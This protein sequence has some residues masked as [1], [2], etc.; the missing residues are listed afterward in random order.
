M[1]QT[2]EEIATALCDANKKVQLIYAF[3]GTGKTRLSR[4]L[5]N[6]IDPKDYESTE[7][8]RDAKLLY[9]N[10]F[11]E[12]LFYWDNDLAGD[13]NRKLIIRPN[14]Y[15]HSVF[16]RNGLEE[17]VVRTFQRYTN[18]SLNAVLS[19][20]ALEV[21][22]SLQRGDD[23]NVE[24]LKISKG[25]ESNFI[26]SIFYCLLDQVIETR[27]IP[28]PEDRDNQFDALEYIVIDDPV[29]SLDEGHLIKLAVDIAELIKKSDYIGGQG[30]RF[31]VTTHNA[32]FFNVLHNELNNDDRALGYR[33]GTYK[34]ARLEKLDEESFRIVDQP[35][36][37]PFSYH[38]H[39]LEELE[40]AIE[41]DDI[42]KYHFNF[43]RNLL[44][45][46]ATF[47][48]HK[49]WE[50]LLPR[51]S[52]DRPNPYMKRIL[53]LSSH[54]KHS[55]EEIPVPSDDDKRMLAYIVKN[56]RRNFETWN[57]EQENA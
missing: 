56:I 35:N 36:D 18:D 46:S 31:I 48:G 10:A 29:S 28:D 47:L 43:V 20:D 26:W 7:E 34:K 6:L 55:G 17:T 19:P 25:E 4:A 45:K 52:D 41:K 38:I 22:F 40:A 37:S 53:N 1:V 21:T 12:D 57:W 13:L 11:T 39:L 32:L 30:L 3:N 50:L 49:K 16:I 8:P 27:N 23:Y 14:D 5:K 15:T 2:L 9:Y 24:N 33:R 54:S 44:E 42:R 51:Q